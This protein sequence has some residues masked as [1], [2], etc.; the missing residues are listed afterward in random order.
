MRFGKI[1]GVLDPRADARQIDCVRVLDADR[2]LRVADRD[3][4]EAK[5]RDLPWPSGGPPGKFGEVSCA[6]PMSTRQVVGPV[7]VGRISPASVWMAERVR[8]RPAARRR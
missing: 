4:L 2:A 5:A 6:R 7:I 8:L 3:V 1:A